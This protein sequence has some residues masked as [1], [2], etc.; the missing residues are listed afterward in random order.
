MLLQ[1]LLP[2]PV[3]LRCIGRHC[4]HRPDAGTRRRKIWSRTL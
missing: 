3:I 4:K 1:T 2:Y